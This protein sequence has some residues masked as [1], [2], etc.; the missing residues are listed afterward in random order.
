MGKGNTD[1][2][3]TNS[4]SSNNYR[5]KGG[6]IK[7]EYKINDKNLVGISYNYSHSKPM[8][9][10]QNYTRRQ[11]ENIAQEFYSDSES[12]NNRKVHN[13]TAFYDVKLDTLGSKLSLSA[14][15][16]LNDAKR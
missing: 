1:Y 4:T 14:N 2:W 10:A 12:R 16:M 15:L 11:S 6:N 3:N 8:E 9:K 7:G 13:E 5:Y